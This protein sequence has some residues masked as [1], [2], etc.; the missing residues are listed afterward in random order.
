MADFNNH[1]DTLQVLPDA[2]S[3]EIKTAYRRLVKQFHPDR[4]Q[5]SGDPEQ[6]IRINAAYEILKD[7][8]NRRSYD[9]QLNASKVQSKPVDSP[10]SDRAPG[11]GLRTPRKRGRAA[12]EQVQ[13]WLQQVYQP[14]NQ[15]LNNILNSLDEQ[16]DELAADPFDDELLEGFQ[17]YLKNCRDFLKEAQSIF[18]S[19]PNPPIV[20]S[21]AAHL[22][23]CLNHLADGLDELNY[24]PLN[25]DDRY[26][27]VGQELFRIAATLHDDV[28]SALADFA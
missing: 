17:D 7:T 26:L 20:A 21:A 1:Y 2:T 9:R 25:Y 11:Y 28:Q 13:K 4:L 5:V 12:D 8:A 23:Y 18:R 22:Y 15:L 3:G 27:H 6:I 14:V 16:I 19:M 24:F 10:K